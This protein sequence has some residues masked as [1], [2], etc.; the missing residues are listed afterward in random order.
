M[1]DDE[2]LKGV[3]KIRHIPCIMVHGRLDFV[4]PIRTAYDLHCAWP[5]AEL[6][7]VPE[8]CH[9]MYDPSITH[10]L[11]SAVTRMENMVTTGS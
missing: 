10:E 7:A 5:E 9:S 2:L 3:D 1:E 6:R 8:A 11:V 4:C